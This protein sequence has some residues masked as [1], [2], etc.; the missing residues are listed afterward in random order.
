[1]VHVRFYPQFTSALVLP[2]LVV[3]IAK[4]PLAPYNRAKMEAHARLM[5]PA[6]LALAPTATVGQI[7]K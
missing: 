6:I 5:D 4:S 3:S 7:A 1:M 2:V